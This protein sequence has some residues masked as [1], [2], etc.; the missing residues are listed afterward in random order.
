MDGYH[1]NQMWDEVQVGRDSE[2]CA[3]MI[4]SNLTVKQ[5]KG[6]RTRDS[7]FLLKVTGNWRTLR[8][9]W[10]YARNVDIMQLV[11]HRVTTWPLNEINASIHYSTICQINP[12]RF[13][14]CGFNDPI[15]GLSWVLLS[16][17]NCVHILQCT[18][19]ILQTSNATTSLIRY[20]QYS[21]NFRIVFYNLTALQISSENKHTETLDYSCQGPS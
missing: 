14:H 7:V 8:N 2:C 19:G 21:A 13:I 17:D 6:N 5:K 10:N 20:N 3:S 12:D 18:S 9:F 4:D 11:A 16:P 15:V 1:D